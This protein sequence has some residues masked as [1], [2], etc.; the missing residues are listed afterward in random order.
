MQPPITVD[1]VTTNDAIELVPLADIYVDD[2][3]VDLEIKL[4]EDLRRC[5]GRLVV[6]FSQM[7]FIKDGRFKQRVTLSS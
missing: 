2:R 1:D 7:L 6:L 5:Y 3:N 4:N